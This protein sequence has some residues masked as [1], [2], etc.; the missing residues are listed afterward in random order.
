MRTL[1][2][3]ALLSG[4]A[5]SAQAQVSQSDWCQLQSV[6]LTRTA[7][8]WRGLDQPVA[9]ALEQAGLKPGGPR[10]RLATL[11]WHR[12]E[13]GDNEE[14]ATRAVV[15][16][17][18]RENLRALLDDEPTFGNQPEGAE[19]QICSDLAT[20][21]SGYL[22]D[23]GAVNTPL[24]IAVEEF[25]PSPSETGAARPRLTEAMRLT[26]RF[27]SANRDAKA[28]SGFVFQHCRSLDASA[29]AQLD[30]EFYAR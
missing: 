6:G 11:A 24:D 1:V 14:A 25:A 26:Q 23:P 9:V 7:V 2:A 30:Q 12:L 15:A 5:T 28:I 4:L 16:A 22:A 19:A 13:A 29:R 27:A 18:K 10:H 20:S 8:T 21:L 3:F 17:C